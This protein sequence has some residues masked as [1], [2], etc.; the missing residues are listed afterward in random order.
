MQLKVRKADGSKEEYLHTKV[1]ATFSNALG[2]DSD[3]SMFIASQ[4]AEIVTFFLYH[5]VG[6]STVTSSEIFSMIQAVL[7]STD[8]MQAALALSDHHCRRN[9]SRNRIKVVN[10]DLADF[11]DLRQLTHAKR[12]LLSSRW[13]KSIIIDELINKHQFDHGIARTI[14]SMA[15][16]RII[17]M[18]FRHV[19]CS[20]VKQIV[21]NEAAAALNATEQLQKAAEVEIE[22]IISGHADTDV[23]PG[24]RQEGSCAVTAEV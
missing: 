19:P 20:L 16:E 10:T 17:N 7:T 21:L 9:L 3:D 12:D 13:N 5:S 1:I 2:C 6:R 24:Q 8:F 22:E 14:A 11:A 18:K 15:E 4:L 23:C